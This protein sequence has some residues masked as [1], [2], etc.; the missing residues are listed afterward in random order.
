MGSFG[1]IIVVAIVCGVVQQIVESVSDSYRPAPKV[2]E[3]K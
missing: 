3:P 2:E 1:K